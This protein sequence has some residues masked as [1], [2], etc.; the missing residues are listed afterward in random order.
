[1]HAWTVDRLVLNLSNTEAATVDLDH[2]YIEVFEQVFL[3]A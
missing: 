1:V 2:D 3:S